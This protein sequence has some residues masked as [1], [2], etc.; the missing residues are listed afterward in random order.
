MT[1]QEGSDPEQALE[2]D[3]E[4]LEHDIQRLGDHIDEA[5]D[6]AADRAKEA[7]PTQGD[8]PSGAGDEDT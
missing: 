8:D 2:R 3:T 1:E 5:K 6:Q 7:D 4:N